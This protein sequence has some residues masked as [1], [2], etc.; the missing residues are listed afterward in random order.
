VVVIKL[1]VLSYNIHKGFN[2][3]NRKFV[4]SRIR[5][6][7]QEVRP[8]LV[9]LQE[10]VGDH[11]VYR[12]TIKSWPSAAQFDYLAQSVWPHV[13]Y[14]KNAEYNAGH[15]GNAILS[16]FPLSH[17]ANLNIYKNKLERRGLLHATLNIAGRS[18]V[19]VFCSHFN[20]LKKDRMLQVE[21]LCNRIEESVPAGAPL[22]VGGDFN[23]WGLRIS[24]I[25]R[26]RLALREAH[27]DHHETHARTFPSMMPVLKLD[28][29]YFRGLDLVDATTMTGSPWH[30]LSDHAAVYAELAFQPRPFD[31]RP[32]A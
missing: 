14:G 16:K 6:A 22:I 23:D 15:H 31:L 12:R 17:I 20:L 9:F 4:L 10:V 26:D 18:D 2:I 28:R 24:A 32:S 27:L 8:D 11:H 21:D 1:K 13:A 5:D 29:I 19:H 30:K 3:G 7:I 25:L